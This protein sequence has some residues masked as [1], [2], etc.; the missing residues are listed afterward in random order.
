MCNPG[1]ESDIV[2]EVDGELL[3]AARLSAAVVSGHWRDEGVSELLVSVEVELQL[4]LGLIG[5]FGLFG[6]VGII[7]IEKH[8]PIVACSEAIEFGGREPG[9]SGD[10]LVMVVKEIKLYAIV[11]SLA[12]DG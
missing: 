2:E 8:L 7:E 10:G 9:K 1:C 5:L 4:G 3:Q 11:L 6:V 12:R